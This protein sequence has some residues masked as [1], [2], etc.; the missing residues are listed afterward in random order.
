MSGGGLGFRER[1]TVFRFA[2]AVAG[3]QPLRAVF[4]GSLSSDRERG[5]VRRL[6]RDSLK[7]TLEKA[8]ELV[9]EHLI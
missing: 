7:C 3:D 6:V 2:R 8:D 1:Q 4:D 9:S 5:K